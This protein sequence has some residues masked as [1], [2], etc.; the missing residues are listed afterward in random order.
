MRHPMGVQSALAL[1]LATAFAAAPQGSGGGAL[2]QTAAQEAA[3]EGVLLEQAW[4]A[5]TAGD[6]AAARQAWQGAAAAGSAVAQFNLGV[7]AD[8][9][10]LPGSGDASAEGALARD[11]AAALRAY[12]QA[13]AQG[14][15]GAFYTL[16]VMLLEGD[17]GV[18]PDRA[19]GLS[20]LR[21]AA[22]AGDV[23]AQMRLGE[24][25]SAADA[26]EGAAG[27]AEGAGWYLRAAETDHAP[28]QFAVSM[29]YA[30][31]HGFARDLGAAAYWA[32][33]AELTQMV[34]GDIGYCTPESARLLAA[35]RRRTPLPAMP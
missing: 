17:I 9:P 19:E 13:A 30:R 18:A 14:H 25:L 24:A 34:T 33:R 5:W 16:G 26:P 20:W 28:A 12:R 4:R 21:R 31:G 7:L 35:C 10:P 6:S 2:A 22:E 11:P 27:A 15:R 23:M 1:V 32:E 29:L 3:P 8:M